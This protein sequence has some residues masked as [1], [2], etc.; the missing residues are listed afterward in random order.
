MSK[1]PACNTEAA[2]AP[3]GATAPG[4]PVD[5]CRDC[6]RRAEE[7]RPAPPDPTKPAAPIRAVD[8]LRVILEWAADVIDPPGKRAP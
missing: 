8:R 3:C 7:R 6:A 2:C 1:C 4:D 5:V